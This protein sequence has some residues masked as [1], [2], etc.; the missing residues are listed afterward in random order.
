[1]KI[2]VTADIEVHTK[3]GDVYT[4]EIRNVFFS[5]DSVERIL[6]W[7]DRETDKIVVWVND[8]LGTL[9]MAEAGYVRGA[10]AIKKNVTI[11]PVEE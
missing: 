6:N 10:Y 1:M 8:N 2:I 4:Q 7:I 9:E 11:K 3:A 5:D